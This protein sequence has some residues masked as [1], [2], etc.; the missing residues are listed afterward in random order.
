MKT[1]AHLKVEQFGD[2]CM[3][4]ELLGNPKKPEPDMFLVRFPGGHVEISRTSDNDYWAHV[5]S[6]LKDDGDVVADESV[7][8]VFSD[9]RIDCKGK[10]AGEMDRGDFARPDAYHVAFRVTRL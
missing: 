5:V 6:Y 1:G 9:C 3:G 2:N 10:H 8:G 7:P 4:V